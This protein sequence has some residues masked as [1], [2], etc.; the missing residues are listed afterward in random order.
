METTEKL[1]TH[2][3]VPA[4]NLD[5]AS[6]GSLSEFSVGQRVVRWF[7]VVSGTTIVANSISAH[8]KEVSDDSDDASSAIRRGFA[9]PY[10]RIAAVARSLH[11]NR[12]AA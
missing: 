12:E 4:I 2:Q 6:C 8:D 5:P 11:V 3:K 7:L 9:V 10:L 1:N